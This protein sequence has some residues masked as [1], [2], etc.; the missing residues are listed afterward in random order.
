MNPHGSVWVVRMWCVIRTDTVLECFDKPEGLNCRD[1][2]AGVVL[3]LTS[4]L[5]V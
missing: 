1:M 3:K 2:R 4:W 5:M